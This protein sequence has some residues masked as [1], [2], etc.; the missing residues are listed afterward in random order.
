MES[1]IDRKHLFIFL[2][3]A[4]GIAWIIAL[5]VFLTGGLV[6]SPEIVP[7]S[8]ITLAVVLVAVGYMWAPAL[9]HIFTRLIT[10]QGWQDLWLKP[11]FK[12]N[13]KYWVIAWFGPGVLTILGIA[14]YFLVFPGQYDSNLTMLR[15]LM[16]SN[17]ASKGVDPWT[18]VLAQTVSALVM[19]PVINSIFTL[20]EEFGWRA[21]MLPMLRP[22]GDI[23]A[24]LISGVIWG[25]WH[26]PIIAMGHNYGLEY[27]G[28]PWLGILAMTW[29]CILCGTFLGWVSGR[30]ASVWPAV[31]GHAA[32][33]G[34]AG[35]G[36]LFI[37]N[38]KANVL[39][40]PTPVGV[41]SSVG[42]LLAT[43]LI[44]FLPAK[45]TA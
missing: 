15:N 21:Y 32:L 26:A 30:A 39:L 14:A 1:S 24:Y 35:L 33:N 17:P 9:A 19:A 6:N 37:A 5:I 38:G 22:L 43:L 10:R 3:F 8:K 18:V 45:K 27:T 4:F 44:F 41:L 28:Y 11:N 7:G 31:I 23:K 12:Q 42:F 2:S 20:G 29:F 13:F 36:A 25:L 34:I 40:G 16:A